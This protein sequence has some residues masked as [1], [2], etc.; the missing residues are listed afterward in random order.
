MARALLSL[1]AMQKSLSLVSMLF[2]LACTASD[3]GSGEPATEMRGAAV[4]R[5]SATDHAGDAQPPATPPPQTAT[6]TIVV[7]GQGDLPELDPQCALD[8]AGQFEAVFD[9]ALT[10]DDDGL[11]VATLAEGS[12][13]IAT[14]SGCEVPD[15]EGGVVTDVRVRA[16]L[17]ATTANC[18]TYCA[19]SARADAEAECG[20]SASAAECRAAAEADAQASCTT[21]CTTETDV[22]VAE[23][24]L[25]AS[26]F[27]DVDADALR[28]AALGELTVD[29]VFDRLE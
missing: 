4:Y 21:T 6:V 22:I 8:P 13:V 27:G 11:Y 17:A 23:T 9:G 29:L 18:E 26:L 2:L 3:D 16:E 7:E 24:S 15:L 5:D 1:L 28:A 10:L 25:S 20:A 14:P 19:A 12:G